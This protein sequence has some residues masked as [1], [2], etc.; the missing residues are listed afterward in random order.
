MLILAQHPYRSRVCAQLLRPGSSA[1]LRDTSSTHA[2]TFRQ[3]DEDNEIIMLWILCVVRRHMALT[4]VPMCM[5][6]ALPT[7]LMDDD[8]RTVPDFMGDRYQ[9]S[10][11]NDLHCAEATVH[12][13]AASAMPPFSCARQALFALSSSLRHSPT[14]ELAGC[15]PLHVAASTICRRCTVHYQD[16]TIHVLNKHIFGGL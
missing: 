6:T 10:H 3:R 11:A 2:P 12:L 15:K 9:A 14:I 13:K 5:P 8:A 1:P 4:A 16:T 7:L